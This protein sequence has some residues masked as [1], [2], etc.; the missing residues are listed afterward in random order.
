[1]RP[2]LIMVEIFD[3]MTRLTGACDASRFVFC[4]FNG[5]EKASDSVMSDRVTLMASLHCD[6]GKAVRGICKSVSTL[7]DFKI[8]GFCLFLCETSAPPQLSTGNTEA[9]EEKANIHSRIRPNFRTMG[10]SYIPRACS[11]MI[12]YSRL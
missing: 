3:V 11:M 9:A 12:S 6:T 7:P 2:E 8:G 4:L 10:S 1:M 5:E